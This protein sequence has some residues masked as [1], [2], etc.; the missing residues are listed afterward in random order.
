MR[1]KPRKLS[2]EI[3]PRVTLAPISPTRKDEFLNLVR[4]SLV[5]HR[6][7]VQPPA[8][9]A[10]FLEFHKR[11]RRKS[12]KS[13]FILEI[14]T[15]RLVG[16]VNVS[17]IVRGYFQSAYL[18]YYVFKPFANKGYMSEAL[19]LVLKEAFT[20]LDLHRLEANIQTSNRPSKH[21]V[22]NLGFRLEGFSPRYLQVKGKWRDHERWA[23][24]IEDWKGIGK[25]KRK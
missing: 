4:Q 17:N 11:S 18:G 20:K 10:K 7:L 23:I 24:T 6:N 13:F 1:R 15:K 5:F 8:T 9:E 12:A 14:V 16:V 2:I 25:S 21:V 19:H 3:I 22:Q